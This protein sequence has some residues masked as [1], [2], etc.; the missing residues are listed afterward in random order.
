MN[1]VFALHALAEHR[2][3]CQGCASARSVRTR[4]KVFMV[5]SHGEGDRHTRG[6]LPPPR[7]RD[8]NEEEGKPSG[9][10]RFLEKA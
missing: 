3:A 5:I 8:V 4:W 10:Y 2:A 7:P 9:I 1:T 6:E